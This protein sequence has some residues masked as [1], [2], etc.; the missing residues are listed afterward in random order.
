MK[1]SISFDGQFCIIFPELHSL[2]LRL[3]MSL[4]KKAAYHG[5][6]DISWFL[7]TDLDA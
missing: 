6:M 3:S 5:R 4:W 2:I 1:F 7:D